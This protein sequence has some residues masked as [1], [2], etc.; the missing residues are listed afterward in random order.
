MFA[1][2]DGKVLEKTSFPLRHFVAILEGKTW[3]CIPER[4]LQAFGFKQLGLALKLPKPFAN[5][6]PLELS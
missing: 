3:K 4:L 2:N 5:V 1:K 6:Y